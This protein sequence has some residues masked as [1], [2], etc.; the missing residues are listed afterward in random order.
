M[1]HLLFTIFI[2]FVIASTSSLAQNHPPT[3]ID[4]SANTH[5]G[6]IRM[7][8]LDNDF[9]IDGN[10][11]RILVVTLSAKHGNA[12]RINDSTIEYKSYPGFPGG[13]DSFVYVI[14]DNGIPVLFDT[15][16]VYLNVDNSFLFDTVDVNNINA[17]FNANG[18]LFCENGNNFYNP[19]FEVPAGSGKHTLFV[20]N[21]WMG[22]MDV[23]GGLHLAAQ[24]YGQSGRDFWAGPVSQVYDSAYDEKWNRIWNI[25]K[26]DID[27]H[28]AHCWQPGYIPSQALID[29]PG[30]GDITQ[31]Q[32]LKTA[33]FKD[34]NNDGVYDPYA[35]D[36]PIIKGDEAVY[37][38]FNDDRNLHT[39]SGGVKL[40][41]E[42][43]AMAYAFNCQD[44]SAL[45]NTLFLQYQLVNRSTFTYN[46]TCIGTF[47][48]FDNGYAWDDYIGC[49]VQ[50]GAFYC[51]N[52]KNL[53]GTGLGDS[54]GP[55]P[56]AQAV[57]YLAGP[58]MDGDGTDNPYGLCDEGINGL[59]FGNGIG[60]DERYGLNR[61]ISFNNI[62]G[63]WP[64]TD[65]ENPADYFNLMRGIWKDGQPVI[66]WGNGHPGA[67]GTGPVCR[68]MYPGDSDT[69]NWG[70]NGIDPGGTNP[71]TEFQAGNNP[72]DRRG[73]GSAGPFTFKAGDYKVLDLAFVFARNFTDTSAVA[74]IPVMQQRIDSIRKYFVN[75]MTPCGGGFSGVK[76]PQKINPQLNIYPNPAGDFFIIEYNLKGKG[77]YE[78]FDM[79]GSKVGKG[80]L[81]AINKQS[82]DIS[83]LKSGLY[84][85]RIS[86]EA[87]IISRKFIKN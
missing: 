75:D 77:Q 68:F 53:D 67:G 44:D 83:N 3:A 30:N 36:F 18:D 19:K 23:L 40:G 16:V 47:I 45:W 1:R 61:F 26:S 25:S 13:A 9:D 52:G 15:A 73:F 60:D 41:L 21:L 70:T 33:P 85:L 54:Y 39:E 59:N 42:V 31:G 7:D 11:I 46:E 10:Y 55:H 66:Y 20:G 86:D 80:I 71:W 69:C 27:Y 57:V 6:H 32:A 72:Y 58:E 84:F 22:A 49:D 8:V 48:D 38:I 78:I 35:G 14:R 64:L 65:P 63:F 43:R 74:A 82:I 24:R 29:W 37:F 5:R 28:L 17:G 87:T 51:Y 79:L 56:P 2:L 81:G 76:A 50:R 62:G 4:D 12:I 34:W